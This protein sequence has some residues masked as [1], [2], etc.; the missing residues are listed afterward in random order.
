M[1]RAGLAAAARDL[2]LAQREEA[3]RVVERW[4]PADEAAGEPP[5]AWR[6]AAESHER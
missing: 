3:R 5:A 2:A 6:E 1:R 4:E